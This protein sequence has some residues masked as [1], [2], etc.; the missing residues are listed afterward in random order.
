M[1]ARA[2]LESRKGVVVGEWWLTDGLVEEE[3]FANIL[4][5]GDCAF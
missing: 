3:G 5:F 1:P 4:N 2:P